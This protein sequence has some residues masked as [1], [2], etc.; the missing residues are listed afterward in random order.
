MATAADFAAAPA[1]G[2]WT[3]ANTFRD[4]S[5]EEFQKGGFVIVPLRAVRIPG[6][7]P[8]DGSASVYTYEADIPDPN[9]RIHERYLWGG[10]PRNNGH[11]TFHWYHERLAFEQATHLVFVIP[12]RGPQTIQPKSADGTQFWCGLDELRE[13]TIAFD[14]TKGFFYSLCPTAFIRTTGETKGIPLLLGTQKQVYVI[15]ARRI[16]S[17]IADLHVDEEVSRIRASEDMNRQ[18]SKLAEVQA[19]Q[20]RMIEADAAR[21]ANS[22]GQAMIDRS[23]IG[24][25]LCEDIQLGRMPAVI[26]AFLEDVRGEKI[27]L[28]VNNVLSQDGHSIITLKVP[29]DGVDYASG[30]VVWVSRRDWRACK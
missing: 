10:V 28:R 21:T 8:D 22:R 16:A 29:V 14:N 5:F 1:V 27:Q 9:L 2:G 18:L 20:Q 13:T 26:S 11:G 7:D 30:N 3:V 19:E 17:L 6:T 12:R 25:L 23:E 24:S 15:D 4:V